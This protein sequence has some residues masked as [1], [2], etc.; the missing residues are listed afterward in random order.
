MTSALTVLGI[1]AV[2]WSCGSGTAYNRCEGAECLDG[3]SD[4]AA[5]MDALTPDGAPAVDAAPGL[6]PA[7]T[8]ALSG[9]CATCPAGSTN[10]AGDDP[11]G[12]DT[13]CDPILCA[14]NEH[15]D[16]HA[17]VAC[18]VGATNAAGD[19]ASGADTA[20]E[21]YCDGANV[22]LREPLLAGALPTGTISGGSFGAEG[23]TT[24]A[25]SDQ[26]FWDL[27]EVVESGSVTFEARGF[28]HTVGGCFW[29]VCYYVGLFEEPS[30]DKEQDYTGSAFIESRYHNDSQENFHDTFK[31]QTGIGDG[32]MSEP[33]MPEGIG[34]AASEWHA[35]RIEWGGG[36]S[37]FYID[38]ALELTSPYSTSRAIAWRYLFLGTTNY[39]GSDWGATGVTYRMLCLQR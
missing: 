15:V 37:R 29:G 39:K 26:L 1:A 25:T 3:G 11:T 30:G 7:D 22:V 9:V 10:E 21:D 14:D 28:H 34:W 32:S 36:Q 38:G 6:C 35:F 18:P 20:C 4:G 2:L 24:G 5:P 16:T 33:M 19:D 12:G 31:L 8:H 23:W 13:S 17:C 27:G